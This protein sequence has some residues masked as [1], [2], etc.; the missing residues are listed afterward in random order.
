MS[1]GKIMIICLL[2]GQIKKMLYNMG[3]HFPKPYERF[4]RNVEVKLN[5]TF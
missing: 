4:G 5:L 1:S 2:A 3:Q